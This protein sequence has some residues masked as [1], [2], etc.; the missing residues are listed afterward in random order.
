MRRGPAGHPPPK[1]RRYIPGMPAGAPTAAA[2]R[3][4]E[5]VSPL[6]G[7]AEGRPPGPD[8][9]PCHHHRPPRLTGRKRQSGEGVVRQGTKGVRDTAGKAAAPGAS[10]V[11]STVFCVLPSMPPAEP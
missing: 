2:R 1:P 3:R 5:G 7:G 8:H 6:S 10:Y 4:K 9:N 11:P